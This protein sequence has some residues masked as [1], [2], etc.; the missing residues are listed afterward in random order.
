MQTSRSFSVWHSMAL[1]LL[2][3]VMAAA[4]CLAAAHGF[5]GKRYFPAT[6][7]FDDPFTQDEFGF[8]YRLRRGSPCRWAPPIRI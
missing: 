6:L 8:L 1:P 4:P 7:T 5:A 3:L 2:S